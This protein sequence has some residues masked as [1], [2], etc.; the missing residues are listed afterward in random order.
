MHI[1]KCPCLRKHIDSSGK[2]PL[3]SHPEKSPVSVHLAQDT[4]ASQS[5]KRRL[6]AASANDSLP[7]KRTQLT[8]TDA[9]IRPLRR[10]ARLRLRQRSAGSESS[11]RIALP[12]PPYGPQIGAG[13]ASEPLTL[14]RARLTR[15]NTKQLRVER[16]EVG[17]AAETV[18]QHQPP[19]LEGQEQVSPATQSQNRQIGSDGDNEHQLQPTRLTRN[20]LARFNKMARKKGTKASG[21]A[22]KSTDKSLT[23]ETT[24]TTKTTSTTTSSFAIKAYKNDMLDTI[25]SKPPTNHREIRERHTRSRETPPATESAHDH[26][27]DTVGNAPNEATMVV[28]V[29]GKLLK[30]YDDKGYHRAFNHAFTGFPE[31]VGFNNGLSAPQPDFVE[32]PG[33]QEFRPFPVDEHVDGAVLYKNN[34]RSLVLPHLAGE[35]KGPGKDMKEAEL[36]AR[37]DGAALVYARRKALTYL[38]RSDPPGH[39]EVTTFTTDG[40]SLHLFAHYAT[41]TEDKTLEY[42]QHPEASYNLMKFDEYKDGQR[43]VRNEQ[44]HAKKQSCD[45][46]DQL[47]KHWKHQRHSGLHPNGEGVQL[48]P[49][50][51]IEP[52]RAYEDEAADYEIVEQPCQPTPATPTKLHEA[53]PSH[54]SKSSHNSSSNSHKRKASSPAASSPGSPGHASKRRSYWTKDRKTGD[55]YHKHSNGTVSWLDDD[56]EGR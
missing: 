26:F 10:S 44:D 6:N 43:H 3:P 15:A 42:H 31:D 48:L 24:S 52:P 41:E 29:S 22:P 25:S 35:W 30:E 14:K 16:K 50:A 32:G 13:A 17:R 11:V 49:V 40:T 36:Q 28:E 47:K 39:A 51:G 54:S 12:V 8:R 56:D 53:S 33:M 9:Q 4:T 46:R 20:N 27:V 2:E 5:G 45:L 18:Q 38:G 7:A 1:D 55:Y 37:Y 19:R 34:P 23:T 21:S